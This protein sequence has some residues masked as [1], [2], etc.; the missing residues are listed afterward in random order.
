MRTAPPS[1]DVQGKYPLEQPRGFYV[2]HAAPLR[3]RHGAVVAVVFA[4]DFAVDKHRD[5]GT[6]WEPPHVGLGRGNNSHADEGNRDHQSFI[7]ENVLLQTFC[8]QQKQRRLSHLNPKI[9]QPIY[10]S[11]SMFHTQK[12]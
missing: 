1:Q 8:Q 6:L 4:D 3:H 2:N 5:Q 9:S 7:L 10:F 11:P 12:F